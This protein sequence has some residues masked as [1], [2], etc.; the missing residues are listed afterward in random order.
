MRN[1]SLYVQEKYC[2]ISVCMSASVWV[3]GHTYA[4]VCMWKPEVSNS[5]WAFWGSVRCLHSHNMCSVKSCHVTRTTASVKAK[6]HRFPPSPSWAN[7][8]VSPREHS[9]PWRMTSGKLLFPAVSPSAAKMCSGRAGV[10][11]WSLHRKWLV[12]SAAHL[13]ASSKGGRLCEISLQEVSWNSPSCGSTL[14]CSVASAGELWTPHH[15]EAVKVHW[16]QPKG[17]WSS[18]CTSFSWYGYGFINV[19]MNPEWLF[20]LEKCYLGPRVLLC[21]L[22]FCNTVR[23]ETKSFGTNKPGDLVQG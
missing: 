9:W 19:V 2:S 1:F 18:W 7:S 3:C 22:Q 20:E 21:A 8:L 13:S 15:A 11:F 6:E 17:R 10:G 14:S 4:T 23:E 12:F 5:S 16:T